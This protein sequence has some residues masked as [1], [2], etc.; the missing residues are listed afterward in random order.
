MPRKG[1][2]RA[3]HLP[4]VMPSVGEVPSPRVVAGEG[5]RLTPNI[6]WSHG[7]FAVVRSS[8]AAGALRLQQA[9]CIVL[10]VK[11]SGCIGRWWAHGCGF[12]PDFP[13][14]FAAVASILIGGKTGA[15]FEPLSV[16]P[17]WGITHFFQ[18]VLTCCQRVF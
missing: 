10:R 16:Y 3:H 8:T 4:A 17:M 14:W 1:A 11:Y 7:A 12:P 5:A 6:S 13:F 15:L 2:R 9:E 18:E